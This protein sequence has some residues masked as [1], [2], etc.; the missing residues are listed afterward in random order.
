MSLGWPRVSQRIHC[1]YMQ[2]YCY[3]AWTLNHNGFSL[4]HL[5]LLFFLRSKKHQLSREVLVI[6]ENNCN[7]DHIPVSKHTGSFSSFGPWLELPLELFPWTLL[8]MALF[9][10]ERSSLVLFFLFRDSL[11]IL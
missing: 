9:S 1:L 3:H 6:S 7:I 4:L 10:I 5:A 8:A 2:L 11:V